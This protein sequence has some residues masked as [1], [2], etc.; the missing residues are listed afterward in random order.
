MHFMLY[1]SDICALY[2][3]ALFIVQDDNE[4][5]RCAIGQ[6]SALKCLIARRVH[7]AEIH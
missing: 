7:C 6:Y 5:G 4:V 1:A 3:W 2:H